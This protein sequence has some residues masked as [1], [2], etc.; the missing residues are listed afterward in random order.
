MAVSRR[1]TSYKPRKHL[2]QLRNHRTRLHVTAL[3]KTGVVHSPGSR[4]DCPID[5]N[6]GVDADVGW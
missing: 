4:A 6:A 2:L 5:H 1:N 3:P